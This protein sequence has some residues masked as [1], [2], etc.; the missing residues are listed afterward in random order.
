M[1]SQLD[2]WRRVLETISA[3]TDS[4]IL[5]V[6]TDGTSHIVDF[7]LCDDL[8]NGSLVVYTSRKRCFYVDAAWCKSQP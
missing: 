5:S 3:V 6:E 4:Q 1:M 8:G 7:E 2:E